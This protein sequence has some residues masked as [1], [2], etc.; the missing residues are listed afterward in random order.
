V[1]QVPTPRRAPLP[2][3]PVPSPSGTLVEWTRCDRLDNRRVSTIVRK[4]AT[5]LGQT[6]RFFIWDGVDI[7]INGVV[8]EDV[9]PLFLSSGRRSEKAKPY[10]ETTEYEIQASPDDTRTTGIVKVTFTELPVRAWHNLDN[11]EKRALGISKGAGVSIVRGGRE[12]DYGWFF[13]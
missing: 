3:S 2:I 7:R 6:F 10:G 9:D 5:S 13:M 1:T 8:V 12:V 11:D 4:L